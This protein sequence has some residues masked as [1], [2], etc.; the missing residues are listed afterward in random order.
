M[1]RQR[2]RPEL[3]YT[4]SSQGMAKFVWKLGDKHEIVSHEGIS[5]SRTVK[6]K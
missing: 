4:A 3:Y 5:S 1:Q 6:N 2:L